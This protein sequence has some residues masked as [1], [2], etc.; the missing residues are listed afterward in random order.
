MAVVDFLEYLNSKGNV[1]APSTNADNID[2]PKDRENKPFKADGMVGEPNP[3]VATS[4]S[5]SKDKGLGDQG[6]TEFK[7]D[8]KNVAG[9]LSESANLIQSVR[10]AMISDARVVE[11]LVNELAKSNLLGCLVAELSTYKETYQHLSEIMASEV[12]GQQVCDK[13]VKAMT[14]E[15]SPPFNKKDDDEEEVELSDEDEDSEDMEDALIDDE[16]PTPK[17]PKALEHFTQSLNK[18][19]I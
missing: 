4:G 2:S 5:A 15:I 12:Y 18:K 13:F 17:M 14:E 7:Y 9:K 8:I 3:Y 10:N 1:A 11:H 19:F 16:A 6:S